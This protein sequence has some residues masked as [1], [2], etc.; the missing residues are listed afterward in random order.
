MRSAL[1]WAAV[2][3]GLALAVAAAWTSPTRA[4]AK[5]RTT[6]IE[7]YGLG[8]HI[9]AIGLRHGFHIETVSVDS[10]ADLD[11][12]QV[13][14]VIVKVDGEVIRSLDHLRAVLAESY[15]DGGEVNLTYTRGQSLAQRSIQ[16]HLKPKP[17][18]PIARKRRG[19]NDIDEDDS[20]IR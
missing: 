20:S 8:G 13:N 14:D 11:E 18:R 6:A 10:P 3:P 9:Q 5:G 16:C 4:E 7:R 17:A 12:L 15:M 2:L 1:K 19:G